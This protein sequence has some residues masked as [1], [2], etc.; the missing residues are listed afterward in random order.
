[1]LTSRWKGLSS[2]TNL[3]GGGGK[4]PN[5]KAPNQSSK[6]KVALYPPPPPLPPPPPKAA[7]SKAADFEQ[8]FE[9]RT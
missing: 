9:H 3:R 1:M 7:D 2:V 5:T 4:V 8:N 6:N